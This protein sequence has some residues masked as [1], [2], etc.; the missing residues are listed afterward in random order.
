MALTLA[1]S[2]CHDPHGRERGKLRSVAF[3]ARG[4][5]LERRPQAVADLCFGCHAGP[6]AVRLSSGTTDLGPLFT[7]GGG[8]AH[9]L[10][11]TASGR[12]EL[13]SLRASA[14]GGRLDCSSCHDNPD[15]SGPRGPHTSTHPSLLK[16]A[17]GRERD[18]G[19]L[20]ERANDLC[21]LCHDRQSILANQSFTFHAQHLQGF[22]G[23]GSGAPRRQASGLTEA[24]AMMGIRS[25]RDFRPGR[26]GAYLPGYGEPTV[27]ASC[28]AAHGSPR[29]AGL[30]EFDRAVVTV[31]SAGTISF[32]KSGLGHGTCT[33]SCHGYDHIQARY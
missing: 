5:L 16:A 28:H 14:F 6:E 17:F 10:G 22:T 12:P 24:Q 20:G 2:G 15:P 27:C 29:Q 32:Q 33:L 30:V 9:T 31:G 1:C 4:Q 3:D 11:A 21:F 19:R 13:P 18:M 8:S 26:A 23:T 25:P 7:R